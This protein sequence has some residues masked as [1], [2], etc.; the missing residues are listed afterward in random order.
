MDYGPWTIDQ[1]MSLTNE[2]IQ[3]KL[4][5]KFGASFVVELPGVVDDG[6]PATTS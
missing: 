6:P 3:Q 1:E 2:T 4:Q 5:E